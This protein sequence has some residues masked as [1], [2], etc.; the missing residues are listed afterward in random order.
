M[1]PRGAAR[2]SLEPYATAGTYVNALEPEAGRT[3]RLRDS[4]GPNWDRLVELKRRYDPNNLVRLNQNITP[5]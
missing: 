4:Y 2:R 5:D 3:N 1:G